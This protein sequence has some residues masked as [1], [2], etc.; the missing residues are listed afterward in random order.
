LICIFFEYPI[1]KGARAYIAPAT[2]ARGFRMCNMT[3]KSRI[4]GKSSAG[5]RVGELPVGLGD[6]SNGSREC[7][8][9][10]EAFIPAL[11]IGLHMERRAAEAQ[12]IMDGHEGCD[13]GN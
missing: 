12:G 2:A 6:F 9:S 8:A 7:G 13:V 5:N 10:E 1:G 11:Q 4:G 3:P